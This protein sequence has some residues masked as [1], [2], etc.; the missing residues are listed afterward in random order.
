[1][2]IGMQAR[3]PSMHCSLPTS[4]TI[5]PVNNGR[6][7]KED[8]R[9]N[10]QIR[11]WANRAVYNGLQINRRAGAVSSCGRAPMSSRRLRKV[12]GCGGRGVSDVDRFVDR[13][14]G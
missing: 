1:M 4:Q 11:A 10:M 14:A 13:A 6:Y 5:K 9:Y 3:I 2:G 7:K 8:H 12:A